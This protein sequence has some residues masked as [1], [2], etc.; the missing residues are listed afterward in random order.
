MALEDII[1]DMDWTPYRRMPLKHGP[2][3]DL[4]SCDNPTPGFWALWRERKEEL[5]AA[6]INVFNRTGKKGEWRVEQ[7][8]PAGKRPRIGGQHRSVIRAKRNFAMPARSFR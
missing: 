7:W 4:R 5:K 3:K 6:G 8:V 2:D 1:E